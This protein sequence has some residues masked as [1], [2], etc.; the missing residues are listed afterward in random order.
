MIR[1]PP[2]STRTD[3][4]LPYTSLVRSLGVIREKSRAR[5]RDAGRADLLTTLS[6]NSD[7][8]LGATDGATREALINA[9]NDAISSSVASGMLTEVEG[10][11]Q[12]EAWDKTYQEDRDARF[13]TNFTTAPRSEEHTYEL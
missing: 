3:T 8:A 10:F 1:R 11:E 6:E 12:R 2:R 13:A 9:S 4:L 5:F 7:A